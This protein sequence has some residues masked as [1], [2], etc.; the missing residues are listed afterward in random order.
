MSVSSKEVASTSNHQAGAV[1]EVVSTM[2]DS[3]KLSKSV[4]GRT[5]KVV[6]IAEQTRKDVEN[7]FSITKGNMEKMDEIRRLANN[8]M[9]STQ[10]IKERIVEVQHASDG[11]ISLSEH[12]TLKITEGWKMAHSLDAVF[13]EV[14]NSS[15]SSAGSARKISE[16]VN[17][18]ADAFE[19][20]LLTLKQISDGIDNFVASAEA[21]NRACNTQQKMADDLNGIVEKYSV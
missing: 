16:S 7:G 6:D 18:Q 13:R 12:G 8:T 21:T 1:K 9:A 5:G 14:L 19:Q 2:E 4:A 20:I 10:E 15:E 3:D 11:L 17:Q